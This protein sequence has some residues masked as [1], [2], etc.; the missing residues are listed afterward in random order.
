MYSRYDEIYMMKFSQDIV[1]LIYVNSCVCIFLLII[2]TV[3][4]KQIS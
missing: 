2:T 4:P 1:W 3:H